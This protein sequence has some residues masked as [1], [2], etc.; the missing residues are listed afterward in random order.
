MGLRNWSERS[1]PMYQISHGVETK[2]YLLPRRKRMAVPNPGYSSDVQTP[3]RMT[4][5]PYFA[6]VSAPAHWQ[7]RHAPIRIPM[8]TGMYRAKRWGFSVLGSSRQKLDTVSYSF[9]LV[10]PDATTFH[11]TQS[12]EIHDTN[13]KFL[14]FKPELLHYYFT[15]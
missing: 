7:S 6:Q 13:A 5:P 9:Q 12:N 10:I 14:P 8:V 15:F 1:V 3:L 11:A 2:W 4:T